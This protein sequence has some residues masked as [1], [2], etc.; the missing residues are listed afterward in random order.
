MFK[1]SIVHTIIPVWP[2]DTKQDGDMLY[3]VYT[4]FTLYHLNVSAEMKTHQTGQSFFPVLA[5]LQ[6]LGLGHAWH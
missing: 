1:E 2:V 3:V 6:K 5:F 4:I